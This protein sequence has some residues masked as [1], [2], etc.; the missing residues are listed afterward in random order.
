MKLT[1]F[2][3]LSAALAGLDPGSE[4]LSLW[5]LPCRLWC[6]MGYASGPA[7][8]SAP[9]SLICLIPVPEPWPAVGWRN[10]EEVC[11]WERNWE[12]WGGT[13][14]RPS[15]STASADLIAQKHFVQLGCCLVVPLLRVWVDGEEKRQI[16]HLCCPFLPQNSSLRT[17]HHA[18]L[19]LNGTE[20]LQLCVHSFI[21]QTVVECPRYT[22]HCARFW[23]I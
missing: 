8:S 11:L 4:S 6:R 22:R 1:R 14:L 10:G 23:G 18:L 19:F 13:K 2:S 5:I 7:A 15:L 9:L 17:V 21:Q 16:F 12:V 20:S 3:I